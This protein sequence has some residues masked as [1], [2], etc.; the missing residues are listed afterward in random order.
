M[1]NASAEPPELKSLKGYL[2]SEKI[3]ADLTLSY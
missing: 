1:M 2:Y 3:T